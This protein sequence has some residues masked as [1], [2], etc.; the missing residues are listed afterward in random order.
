MRVQ[1]ET[2][3]VSSWAISRATKRLVRI[4]LPQPSQTELV[5]KGQRILQIVR[6]MDRKMQLLGFWEFLKI[7]VRDLYANLAIMEF[8]N[9]QAFLVSVT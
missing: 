2:E 5:Y 1:G 9:F 3:A 6:G 7:F 8:C 4:P